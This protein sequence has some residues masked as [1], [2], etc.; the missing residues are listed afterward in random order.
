MINSLYHQEWEEINTVLSQM[1]L[2]IK[3]SD[4]AGIQGNL[5]FDPVGTNEYI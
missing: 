2:H 5:I 1:P 4:Q 3:A